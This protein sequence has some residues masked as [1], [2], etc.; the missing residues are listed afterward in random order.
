MSDEITN[1]PQNSEGGQQQPT[2]QAANLI[3]DFKKASPPAQ[4][5]NLPEGFKPEEFNAVLQKVTGVDDYTK[6]S[7]MRS[8]VND[9]QQK[10]LDM[11]KQYEALKA[12]SQLT[13][14]ANDFV[15]RIDQFFRSG[16]SQSEINRFISLHSKDLSAMSPKDMAIQKMM[17]EN[18]GLNAEE[19]GILLDDQLPQIP[20]LTPESTDV[21]K[22]KVS[23]AEKQRE[24]KMKLFGESCAKL[25]KLKRNRQIMFSQF[26]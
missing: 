6:I 10:F 1:A 20:Q 13:P 18:P 5:T 19:A 2:Q 23:Q 17:M 9:Y 26:F 25:N 12:K 22:L 3:Q 7:Q 24:A 21:D 15:E 4:P 16:K 14:Y 11:S 8:D